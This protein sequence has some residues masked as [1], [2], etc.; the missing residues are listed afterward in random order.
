[1]AIITQIVHFGDN[2]NF[3]FVYDDMAMQLV[4]ISMN[5]HLKQK[6]IVEITAQK[7][8]SI[9]ATDKVLEYP[10]LTT[11]RPI[12]HLEEVTKPDTSKKNVIGGIVWRAYFGI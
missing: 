12:Y 11:D 7:E 5:N 3:S 10:I 2:C 8:I 1:M 9:E 6:L 4:S